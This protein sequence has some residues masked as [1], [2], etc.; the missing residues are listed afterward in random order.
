[1]D[2]GAAAP[3]AD[4]DFFGA[5]DDASPAAAAAERQRDLDKLRRLH[6]AAGF[7]DAADGARDAH[8]QAGFD[9]GF[10]SGAAAVLDAAAGAGAGDL[11]RA[12]MALRAGLR[13]LPVGGR[14]DGVAEAAAAVR[15]VVPG[16]GAAN[17]PGAEGGQA[18]ADVPPRPAAGGGGRE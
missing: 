4:D 9:G 13:G 10:L 8:L 16:M 3:A 12:R 18:R 6:L 1:M 17:A 5:Q 2:T 15:A 14:V 7:R 11:R